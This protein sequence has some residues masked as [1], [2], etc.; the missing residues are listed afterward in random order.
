[1]SVFQ[2]AEKGTSA[3][4][5]VVRPVLSVAL[6]CL[7]VVLAA[8]G[9]VT[10]E[11]LTL[12]SFLAEVEQSNPTLQAARTREQA[13]K[14]RVS[15]AG[16]WEDPFF[17]VGPDNVMEGES[18]SVYRYQLAQRVPFPGKLAA[19]QGAAEARATVAGADAQTLTRRILASAAQLFYQAI[20]LADSIELN[21]KLQ[22]VVRDLENSARARYKAGEGT[23]H[24]W[25]LAKSQ[26]AILQ[27]DRLRL[28]RSERTLH[29]LLNEMRSKPAETV[30]DKLSYYPAG[31]PSDD[32]QK[33]LEA[34]PEL[35]SLEGNIAA[36]K[37]E[38]RAA[39]LAA[40]PDLVLQG[41]L[42][43]D[44]D[45]SETMWG[46]MA[47]VNIPIFYGSKQR[48][49]AR[50]AAREAQAVGSDF[51][52]LKNRL[53]TEWHEA[54]RQQATAR[55]VLELYLKSIVPTTRL[56]LDAA[57]SAYANKSIALTEVLTVVQ[58]LETQELELLAA[59][60]DIE[61]ARLRMKYLLAMPPVLRFAP[62]RPTLFPG[63]MQGSMDGS[64]ASGMDMQQPDAIRLGSGIGLG[65]GRGQQGGGD[66]GSSG[67]S[68]MGGM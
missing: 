27:T 12:E 41:M 1:M 11:S 40:F 63:G 9:R 5:A 42:M 39:E 68:D 23:H 14:L 17:A 4:G 53:T 62:T 26:A 2:M 32:L 7:C 33:A 61:L 25:L 56:A 20:Y 37:N 66:S 52:S 46:A 51:E 21:T 60:L 57:R 58:S 28:E 24:Q 19:R 38:E 15:P 55:D 16:S 34:S 49:L 13:A 35:L 59:K 6:F 22:A 29:A 44:T 64:M 36:A 3:E 18:P 10:A 65:A 67:M 31:A 43:R 47:G 50:A 54:R 45:E 8:P 30:I 48:E